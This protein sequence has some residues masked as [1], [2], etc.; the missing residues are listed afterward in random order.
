MRAEDRKVSKRQQ[1]SNWED[2]FQLRWIPGLN[3]NPSSNKFGSKTKMPGNSQICDKQNNA[4]G[5]NVNREREIAA[6]EREE[7]ETWSETN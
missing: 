3:T 7:K 6:A 2:V 1:R 4:K 5:K